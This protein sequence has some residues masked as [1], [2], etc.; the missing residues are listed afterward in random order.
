V[1]LITLLL[2]ARARDAFIVTLV[3]NA[4]ALKSGGVRIAKALSL[5]LEIVASCAVGFTDSS[6]VHVGL[7]IYALFVT[8]TMKA[9]AAVQLIVAV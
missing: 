7:T 3:S 4:S 6:H 9:V 5:S 8:M 2:R 1:K